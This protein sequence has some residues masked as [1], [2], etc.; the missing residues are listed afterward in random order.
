MHRTVLSTLVVCSLTLGVTLP[1]LAQDLPKSQPKFITVIRESV[2]AGRAADHAKHEAGWPAA[3]EKAKSPDHY[4][5]MTS[6]TGPNEAW[7]VIPWESHAA[8]GETMKRENKDEA[9]SK[10]L[11]RLALQDA[12]YITE[13]RTIQARARNDLSVG[14]FPDLAKTRFFQI[15]TMRVRLGQEQLFEEAAKA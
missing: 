10:E 6:L 3:F 15:T 13:T 11:E 9:L 14:E 12:E 2:K 7:Y 1:A 8:L 5:A 4:L